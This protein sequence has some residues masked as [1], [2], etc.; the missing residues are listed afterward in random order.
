MKTIL[1]W[2]TS[3]VSHVRMRN[4][5][6]GLENEPVKIIDV[7]IPVWKAE[8][9]KAL[10]GIFTTL[11]R[12]ISMLLVYPILAVRYLFAPDHD[13]ILV[14]YMGQLDLL[15]VKPLAW[16]RRKPVVWDVYISLFDTLVFDRKALSRFNPI[17]QLVYFV[18][19]L[20]FKIAD[21]AIADTEPHARYLK[22]LFRLK[23]EP[24]TVHIGAD[25]TAFYPIDNVPFQSLKTERQFS[26]LFYG[27]LSPMHGVETIVGA[28]A[29]LSNKTDIEFII[30]GEG[31]SS[32]SIDS[33]ISE[34]KLKNIIRKSHVPYKELNQHLN[35]SNIGL[36]IFA[37]NP[38]G[39]KVVPNKVY[40]MLASGISIITADTLGVREVLGDN[41]L[42][43][44]VPFEDEKALADTIV[45]MK[46]NRGNS[47]TYTDIRSVSVTEK[48]V[49]QQFLN[50]ISNAGI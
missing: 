17:S 18:E 25:S 21:L 31:Q 27:N 4:L 48:H 30:I 3:D 5:M 10:L 6:A 43:S 22:K 7:T 2:S 35:D 42:A 34:K 26:V 36:G 11:W 39:N 32:E 20:D 50:V 49:A 14:P 40:Q 23:Q 29:L 45:R 8:Q 16:I 41:P 12:F 13:L 44:Y 38:K 47:P 15:L 33:L 19:W 46:N 24:S 9:N 1:I 37:N 28:A